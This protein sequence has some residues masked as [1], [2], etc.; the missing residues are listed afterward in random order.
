MDIKESVN[1]MEVKNSQFTQNYTKVFC[2]DSW[3]YNAP[4]HFTVVKSGEGSELAKINFQEGPIK[5]VGVNGV[6]NEDLLLMVVTRLE[7]F[8]NSEYRCIE[9]RGKRYFD[10]ESDDISSRREY[11]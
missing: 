8:Q 6:A 10:T 1:F 5:E 11:F 2:E 9:I 3:Q 4:N 7:A